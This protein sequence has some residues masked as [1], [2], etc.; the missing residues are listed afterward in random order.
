MNCRV[1]IIGLGLIGGSLGLTLTQSPGIEVVG[2]DSDPAVEE[3]ALAIGAVHQVGGY[4]EAA[5]E[6]DIVFLC[7]PIKTIE[8]LAREVARVCRSG[9]IITDVGS[10][11]QAIMKVF[12]RLSEN[13]IWG[14]GGHP[15]AGSEQQGI[16]GADRYLFE[17]A[18]YVLTP[19]G[20][21]PQEVLD[22]LSSI[23]RL[24]GAHII[25][26]DAGVHDRLVAS[27][28]HLPH[29]VAAALVSLLQGQEEAQAL[30]AGG[31]RD[32][33]RVASGDPRLWAEILLSNRLPLVDQVDKLTKRLQELKAILE[34]ER[35]A[36]L[37]DFLQSSRTLR[38]SLPAKRKGLVPSVQDL[39][40]LVPDR[41]G[42]IGVLGSYLGE[43]GINIADIEV[44]RV[45]E[46]DGG[47]IR[48]GLSREDD[49]PAAV[50]SLLAHG[51]K[52][53]LK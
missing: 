2:C 22:R 29:L 39:I 51:I 10:T 4:F 7:T 27:V 50:E 16:S 34:E 6:A 36:D 41:P 44:L 32:T 5:A 40:C 45:R 53:W 42:I 43:K 38:E 33:T 14:I 1:A 19:E 15:M 3:K 30:A 48:I 9:C 28:S 46:G 47:T 17:N 24:T 37:V 23:L 49:G 12:R 52:A 18:V 20:N 25:V 8:R 31:F 26:M 13:G 11:K 35:Q 21:T